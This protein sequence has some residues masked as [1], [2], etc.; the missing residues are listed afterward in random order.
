MIGC[1]IAA[2]L[3][4]VLAFRWRDEPLRPAPPGSAVAQFA[5]YALIIVA[6]GTAAGAMTLGAGGRLAMRLLAA[7]AGDA[8]QGRITEADETVGAITTG[9]T[10]GFIVFVGIIG[11][12]LL[13]A[14]LLLLRRWLPSA[15]WAGLAYG[16]LFAILAATRLDPLRPSNKDFDLVGPGWLAVVTFLSVVTV[17]G[18]VAGAFA[19]RLSGRVPLPSRDLR[20]LAWYSPLLVLVLSG[21]FL[22]FILVPG[23]VLALVSR[24]STVR[25]LAASP[26]VDVVGRWVILAVGAIAVPF[27]ALDLVDIAGRP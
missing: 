20:R 18:F 21:P 15:P 1:G 9:G 27:T 17:F 13:T 2:I 4:L 3:G 16:L 11:G 12:T 7:T 25:R 26:R 14:P 6:V 22:I 23:V 19:G 5:W 8:A 24:L 10:L